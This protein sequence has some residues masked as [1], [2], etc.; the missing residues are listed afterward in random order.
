[1]SVTSQLA[2]VQRSLDRMEN[3]G[4]SVEWTIDKCCDYIAWVAKY[5]KVPRNV[6]LPLCEQATR[7]LK[8]GLIKDRYY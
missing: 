5:K 4:G 8:E 2:R 7:L 3:G 6:W 1:M